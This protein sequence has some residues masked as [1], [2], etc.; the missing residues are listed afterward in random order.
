MLACFAADRNVCP[1]DNFLFMDKLY[2]K[3]AMLFEKIKNATLRSNFAFRG[4]HRR[5]GMT[6]LK[7][8]AILAKKCC[9]V[10]RPQL[11]S[12][13]VSKVCQRVFNIS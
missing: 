6:R 3:D 8:N 1:T 10:F 13:S 11:R 9:Q 12:I 2:G 7:K 4:M 5:V